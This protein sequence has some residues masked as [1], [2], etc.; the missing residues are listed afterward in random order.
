MLA[1]EFS[2]MIQNFI[3]LNKIISV[4]PKSTLSFILTV[5]E[6]FHLLNYSESFSCSDQFTRQGIFQASDNA[7]GP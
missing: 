1:S 3:I 6:V 5:A 7:H 2:K 4:G